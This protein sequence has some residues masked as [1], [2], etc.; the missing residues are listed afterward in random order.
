MP[1]VAP[2]LGAALGGRARVAAGGPLDAKLGD[3]RRHAGSERDEREDEDEAVHGRACRGDARAVVERGGARVGRR[4]PTC[5]GGGVV[6]GVVAER[7]AMPTHMQCGGVAGVVGTSRDADA[8]AAAA[9]SPDGA[10][11]GESFEAKQP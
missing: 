7:V 2:T 4:A 3:T 11:E 1:F 10:L 8:H 5:G 9:P 6:A